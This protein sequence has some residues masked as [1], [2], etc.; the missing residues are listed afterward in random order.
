MKNYTKKKKKKPTFSTNLSGLYKILHDVKG[1][2]R[3]GKP[4]KA[5]DIC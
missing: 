4:I 2:G 3:C 1:Q 5:S